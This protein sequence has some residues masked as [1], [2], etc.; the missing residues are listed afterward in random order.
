MGVDKEEHDCES[1]V[2][3]PRNTKKRR[4]Q[5]KKD[6]EFNIKCLESELRELEE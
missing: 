3:E 2:K 5:R 4:I 1:L 6:I